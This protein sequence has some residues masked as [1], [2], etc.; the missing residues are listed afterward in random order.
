MEMVNL[1]A[2]QLILDILHALGIVR[3]NIRL[4]NIA[5][6]CDVMPVAIILAFVSISIEKV[7]EKLGD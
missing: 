1:K 3:L 6:Q 2:C 5:V 7:T 4:L